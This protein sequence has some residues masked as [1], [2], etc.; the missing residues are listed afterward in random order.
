[1]SRTSPV[2][3]RFPF[4]GPGGKRP[5]SASGGSQPRW[6]RDGKELFFLA[7]DNTLMA[8]EVSGRGEMFEVVTIRT[9]F[10]TRAAGPGYQY[11]VTADGQQYLINTMV[12][13]KLYTPI[14]LVQNWT[15]GLKE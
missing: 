6:H 4:P 10:K 7:P 1:M 12:D 8:A 2:E 11:D 9:L 13:R 14:T 15:A 5:V 3:L